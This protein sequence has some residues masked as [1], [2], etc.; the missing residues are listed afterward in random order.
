VVP[1]NV[2]YTLIRLDYGTAPSAQ[3]D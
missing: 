1:Y 3:P 2:T